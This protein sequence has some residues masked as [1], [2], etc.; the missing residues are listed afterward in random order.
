MSFPVVTVESVPPQGLDVI[1]GSWAT[2]AA[3]EALGGRLEALSGE[4]RVVRS[5]RSLLTG[6]HLSA[7]ALVPC[8][9]CGE[10]VVLPVSGEFSCL[11]APADA[12]PEVD[13]RG[14]VQIA[15]PD[16]WERPLEEVSEFD[17]ESL[18]LA[19]VVAEFLAVERPPRWRCADADPAADAHCLARWKA[20]S[21]VA[22]EGAPRPFDALKD[23]KPRS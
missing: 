12:L 6:G 9:R 5:G 23:W 20:R 19:H 14:D 1:V 3:A 22:G 13:E 2:A 7:R 11:Y 18:D 8:D 17:G 4:L 10:L 16:A 21:G 15:A